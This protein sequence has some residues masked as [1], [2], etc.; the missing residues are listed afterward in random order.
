MPS[1]A[2]GQ[3]TEEERELLSAVGRLNARRRWADKSP[4][5]RSEHA[6]MMAE[7]RWGKRDEDE[8]E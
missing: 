1:T 8:A 2:R 6:R 3:C 7:A 4:E 5:E